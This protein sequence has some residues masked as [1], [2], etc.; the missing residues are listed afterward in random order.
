MTA[1]TM[2]VGG[3]RSGKSRL[4]LE[5]AERHAG[6][7]HYLATAEAGDGEMA[8]RIARHRAERG[9]RWRTIECPLDL[10]EAI[11][12]IPSGA[13]L[14]DCLTLWLSNL[15]LGGHPIER[16]ADELIAAIAATPLP[17]AIVTNEVGLGIVPAHPLG[18]EFRDAAGR[19]NQKV[20]A[21]MGAAYFVVS[22]LVLPLR[23]FG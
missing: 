17:I 1:K 16:R 19:L 23:Q 18:R 11:A 8:A 10:P 4:A 9:A 22:G 20:A 15:M 5:S 14:V 21:G 7:L 6:P 13:I 3:A 12:A 2:F